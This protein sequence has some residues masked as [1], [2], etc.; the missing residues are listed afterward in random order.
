VV[1]PRISF[2][3]I[4]A[5]LVSFGSAGTTSSAI[6]VALVGIRRSFKDI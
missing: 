3:P 5:P 1:S 6:V 4:E 2:R